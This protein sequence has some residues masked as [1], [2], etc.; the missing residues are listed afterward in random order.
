MPASYPYLRRLVRIL[1]QGKNLTQEQLAE[2]AGLDYKYFQLFEIGRTA[3]AELL[4]VEKL[5]MALGIR[6][7][8]LLCDDPNVIH[9]FTGVRPEELAKH[10]KSKPGRPKTR[11]AGS[12]RGA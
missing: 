1:R 5:A 10:L 7:W 4:T 6:A 2:K 3:N 9:T 11:R 12:E 8:I